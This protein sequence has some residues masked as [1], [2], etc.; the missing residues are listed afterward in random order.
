MVRVVHLAIASAEC[1]PKDQDHG[2]GCSSSCFMVLLVKQAPNTHGQTISATLT[3]STVLPI[4]L[5]M[6]GT[7]VT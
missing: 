3:L 5:L 6:L 7:I 4:G 2:Q 1:L